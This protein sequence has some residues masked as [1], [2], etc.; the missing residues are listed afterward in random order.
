MPTPNADLSPHDSL[1]WLLTLSKTLL[2][3]RELDR[4]L[5]LVVRTFLDATDAE[6]A[7]LL[8]MSADGELVNV[9]GANRSGE[10]LPAGEP[11]ISSL[12]AR[13]A[14]SGISIFSP[15]VAGDALGLR[16]MVCVPLT[17]PSGV[18]GVIYAD[19]KTLLST[20]FTLTNQRAFEALADHAA[21][22]IENARLFEDATRDPESGLF[23][24]PY[25]TSQLTEL[26]RGADAWLALLDLD[27]L[28][29][30]EARLGPSAAKQVVASVGRS[31][32]AQL[33]R[34]DI[35]GRLGESL[36]GVCMRGREA[37]V[38]SRLLDVQKRNAHARIDDLEVDVRISI[39]CT[40]I[41]GRVEEARRRAGVALDRAHEDATSLF[42]A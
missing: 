37:E 39:G 41:N 5:E 3:T 25:F 27:D 32:R 33:Q 23:H 28:E 24:A 38:R 40:R 11:H 9:H 14:H 20:V 12:A 1:V 36:F 4:L 26:A 6:R 30:I 42:I 15:D 18:V 7:F 10:V 34:P 29:G 16:M 13:V 22:A 21:A 35:G 2:S 8:L 19:G 17:G 31:L